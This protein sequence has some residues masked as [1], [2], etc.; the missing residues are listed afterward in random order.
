MV[1]YRKTILGIGAAAVAVIG[2]TIIVSPAHATPPI[3][4]TSTPLINGT[5]DEFDVK[6]PK[7]DKWDLM[8]KS[9]GQTDIR[10][11][12][13]TFARDGGQSGWHSHPGPNLL[14]VVSGSVTEYDGSDPVCAFKTYKAGDSFGDNGGSAVHFVINSGSVPAVVMAVAMY[15]AGAGTRTDRDQPTNCLVTP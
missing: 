2:G 7:T 14:Y 1:H 15:P 11:S 9:K 5:F 6:A 8:L 12:R 4:F 13:V 10:V 3:G